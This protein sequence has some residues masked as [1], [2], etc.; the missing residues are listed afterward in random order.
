MNA[1]EFELDF[2][3]IADPAAEFAARFD[4]APGGARLRMRGEQD[5]APLLDWL[6]RERRGRFEWSPL[7]RETG[8]AWRIEVLKRPAGAALKRAVNEALSWDHDRLDALEADAFAARAA[9]DGV[10]A[11][12]LYADFAAGLRRHIGFEERVLFPEFEA[13]AGMPPHAGPT[14]VMRAEHREIE[15]LLAAIAA[16]IATADGRAEPLRARFHAVLGDHND[17]EEQ[18]LY[19][20]TDEGLDEARRDELVRRIQAYRE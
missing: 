8:G 16:A 20:A 1:A 3:V 7:A 4:A 13:I 12:A 6:L 11:A 19:P 10:R 15:T 9:G 5:P 14:A 17:K 18:V 2:T